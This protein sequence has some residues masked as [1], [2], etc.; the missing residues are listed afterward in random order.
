[1]IVDGHTH[2][3]RRFAGMQGLS[4]AEFVE[5]LRA[6]GIDKALV[7]TLEGFFGEPQSANDELAD[8]VKRYPEALKAF[9]TVNPRHGQAAIEELKRC[10]LDLGMVGLKLHNWLQAV[11]AVDPCMFPLIEEAAR[12]EVPVVFHDGTPPYCTTLQV[13]YLAK[14]Y[15][16]ATIILGHSGLNDF[17]RQAI[18]AA[19][20]Y[21]NIY[22]LPCGAPVQG[23][24]EMVE[25]VGVDR[26][27]WG[28]DFPF[29]GP[30]AVVYARHKIECLE[31]PDSD[32]QRIL[33]EN[34][35][36]LIPS[37]R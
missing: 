14:L 20:R 19:L 6:L 24:A 25:T 1:M 26:L 2:F 15:P 36:R 21:D 17:W 11:S 37:L 27:I 30:G 3:F 16:E 29:G 13:A 31:I 23:I 33:G 8:L 4:P 32:K 12:L 28:S 5:G 35:M 7:F 9:C 10:V 18:K 34:I 22:L